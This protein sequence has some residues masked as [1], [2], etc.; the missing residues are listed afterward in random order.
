MNKDELSKHNG[1]VYGYDDEGNPLNREKSKP[2]YKM[3]QSGHCQ[4]P[5]DIVPT[6]KVSLPDLI[7]DYKAVPLAILNTGY[8][9]QVNFPTG[10]TVKV[11]EIT[12]NL[13]QFHFHTPGEHTI[14]GKSYQMEM[15]LVH[16]TENGTLGVI[17]IMIEEGEANVEAEKIWQF[18]PLQK[19]NVITYKDVVVNTK[20]FLP[21]DLSYYRLM[22]S[23]TTPPY[24]EGVDWYI[25]NKSITFSKQQI[26]KF[27]QAFSMNARPLQPSNSRMI[28]LSEIGKKK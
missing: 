14:N 28:I 1:V 19:T 7:F 15:H 16:Q 6:I 13:L 18:L 4:S 5:I 9:I 26:D 20:N 23:L 3:C 10:E 17:G 11:E 22:G 12:Y 8:T 21:K 2:E 27:K 24:T 25:F